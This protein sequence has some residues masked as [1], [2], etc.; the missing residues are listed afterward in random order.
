MWSLGRELSVAP[1]LK[2]HQYKIIATQT[3]FSRL[4]YRC[5][6]GKPPDDRHYLVTAI[7]R[8][9]T[10]TE[11]NSTHFPH[12]PIVKQSSACIYSRKIKP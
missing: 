10:S 8:Y 7:T 1:F 12:I 2:T 9:A 3:L 4:P 5:F 11:P 6:H